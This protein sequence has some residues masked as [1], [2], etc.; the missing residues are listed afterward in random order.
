MLYK[1]EGGTGNEPTSSPTLRAFYLTSYLRKVAFKQTHQHTHIP[2]VSTRTCPFTYAHPAF[3]MDS[4]TTFTLPPTS[5]RDTGACEVEES[6]CEPIYKVLC[7][8]A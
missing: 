2:Y 3:E 6:E 4:F 5:K 7:T 1:S 8:I